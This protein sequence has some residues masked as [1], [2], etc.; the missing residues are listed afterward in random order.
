MTAF[1]QIRQQD[2]DCAV[3]AHGGTLM[4]IMEKF[5]VPEG[6]YFDFQVGNGEG[7]VMEEDGTYR[8]VATNRGAARAPLF[9]HHKIER[10]S[11]IM[12]E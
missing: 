5:A 10:L 9:R 8:R 6:G 3:V 11:V 12:H 7:F 4:A 2:E 1:E